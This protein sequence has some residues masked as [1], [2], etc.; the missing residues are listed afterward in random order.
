MNSDD[1]KDD[2]LSC[3]EKEIINEDNSSNVDIILGLDNNTILNILVQERNV[4]WSS[5]D[6]IL[7]GYKKISEIHLKDDIIKEIDEKLLF[8]PPKFSMEFY[9]SIH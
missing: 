3:L 7:D 1:Q 4:F 8:M 5:L 2:N 6:Y 9:Q